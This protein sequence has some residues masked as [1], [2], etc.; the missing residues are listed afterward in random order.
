M[1]PV[2]LLTASQCPAIQ[3]PGSILKST[4]DPTVAEKLVPGTQANDALSGTVLINRNAAR[5]DQLGRYG[6]GGWAVRNGLDFAAGGGLTL[7][8]NDG[9]VG[10]DTPREMIGAGALGYSTLPLTDGIYSAS[11][12]MVRIWVWVSRALT[13]TSVNNSLAVPPGGPWLSL[14]SVRTTGGSIVDWDFSGRLEAEPILYRRTADIGPPTDA[15]PATLR[16]WTETLTGYYLWNGTRYAFMGANAPAAINTSLAVLE[17][18]AQAA[19]AEADETRRLLRLLLAHYV[20]T[21]GDIPPGLDL[22]YE[23]ALSEL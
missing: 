23:F 16:F 10:L 19:F 17:A 20:D 14:G 21:L 11:D 2:Y 7:R 12:L 9:V 1:P 5:L 6:G 3:V 8:V 4:D 15:P 13:L 22:E 18:D